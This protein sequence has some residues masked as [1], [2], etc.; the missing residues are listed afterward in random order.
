MLITIIMSINAHALWILENI[1]TIAI[2]Y[3]LSIQGCFIKLEYDDTV[4][5][6][7]MTFAKLTLPKL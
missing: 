5:D 1:V 3:V 2:F 6:L 7:L 4:N